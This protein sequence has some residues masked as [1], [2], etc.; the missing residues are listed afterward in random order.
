[1]MKT[2]MKK[3]KIILLAACCC[4][5]PVSGSVHGVPA[6]EAASVKNGWVKEAAGYCYYKNGRKYKNC[7]QTING[8]KY[9][10]GADGVRKT[11]WY[12]LKNGSKYQSCYFDSRGVLQA[13]RTKAISASLVKKMDKAVKAAGVTAGTKK[14]QAL[15]LLFDYV[16]SADHFKY[17]RA[18]GFTG[19]KNWEYSYAESMLGNGQGSC[20]HYA[21]VYAFLAKRATGYPV[22]ICWGTSNAFKASNWQPHAWTEIKIGK[23]WYAFDANAE[24]YSSRKLDWYRQKSSG[25]KCYKKQ[26]SVDVEL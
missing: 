18:I 23:T 1:M 8:K 25:A 16:S 24:R 10:F 26:K 6:V 4:L 9:Y 19:A 21:A 13:G 11:G 12:T 2:A 15:K 7:L 17:A 22:R 3:L 14:E 20:Y 5:G